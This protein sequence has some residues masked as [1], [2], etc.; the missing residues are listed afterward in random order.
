MI[1][2]RL[3]E[4]RLQRGMTQP[5]LSEVLCVTQSLISQYEAGTTTITLSVLIDLCDA[6]GCSVDYL[7]GREVEYDKTTLRGQLFKG[8]EKLTLEQQKT[9]AIMVNAVA[10]EKV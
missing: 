4:I 8:F 10:E 9:I 1:A 5:E 2:R 6:L 7:L 3:K